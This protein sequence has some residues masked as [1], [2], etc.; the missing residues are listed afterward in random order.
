M[1]KNRNMDADSKVRL[2][3]FHLDLSQGVTHDAVILDTLRDIK[4]LAV[5]SIYST[6]SASGT[7]ADIEVGTTA[8]VDAYVNYTTLATQSLWT[9][10]THTLLS[11]ALVPA[12]TAVVVGMSGAATDDGEVDLFIE[13]E[14]VDRTQ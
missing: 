14:L 7:H 6:A 9:K 5:S 3:R 1:I 12:G 4:I 8:D 10:I 13:Y 2:A 11:T